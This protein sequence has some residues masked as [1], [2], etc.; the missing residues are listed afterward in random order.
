MPMAGTFCSLCSLQRGILVMAV[1]CLALPDHI[2]RRAAQPGQDAGVAPAECSPVYLRSGNAE[3]ACLR[4]LA[5]IRPAAVHWGLPRRVCNAW[6]R[7]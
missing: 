5:I 3:Q 6:V 2:P 7:G 1:P 4:A